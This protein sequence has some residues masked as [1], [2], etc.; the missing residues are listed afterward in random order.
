MA[1]GSVNN[2]WQ[3]EVYF[4]FGDKGEVKT[5]EGF[6]DLDLDDEVTVM[7]TGKVVGLSKDQGGA[8]MRIQMKT[9]E[10]KAAPEQE[11]ERGES[12]TSALMAQHKKARKI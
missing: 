9:V 12:L 11:P 7:I 1:K 5:P 2:A 4:D 3:R 6:D 10:L 8:N